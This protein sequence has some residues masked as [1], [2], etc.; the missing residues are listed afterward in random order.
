MRN[1]TLLLSLLLG[2]ISHYTVGQN[3]PL[4]PRFEESY[5]LGPRV[6]AKA[7]IHYEEYSKAYFAFD[8]ESGFLPSKVT[9]RGIE[10]NHISTQNVEGTEILI[11]GLPF[12]ER[13]L[14]T[15]WD[16][17]GNEI[18][19]QTLSS[20]PED[21]HTSG[22]EVSPRM[23]ETLVDWREVEEP[24][25]LI[26]Y[27]QEV[28]DI[29]P[30]EKIAFIQQHYLKGELISIDRGP[31]FPVFTTTDNCECSTV[32]STSIAEPSNTVNNTINASHE[33]SVNSS[34]GH[35]IS[36]GLNSSYWWY[37]NNKGPAKWHYLWGEG[38]KARSHT[39]SHEENTVNNQNMG[40]QRAQLAY[41][42]V[43]TGRERVPGDCKTCTKKLTLHYRYDSEVT[44][45]ARTLSGG[46]GDK[47]AEAIAQDQAVVTL[48]QGTNAPEVLAVQDIRSSSECSSSIN[49]DWF[50]S[51]VDLALPIAEFFLIG[52]NPTSLAGII[53]NSIEELI[54]EPIVER[55]DC[56]SAT[57]QGTLA[58]NSTVV[59]LEANEPLYLNIFSFS[60]QRIG[61]KRSWFSTSGIESDFYMMGILDS[62]YE[63]ETLSKLCCADKE[64][65]WLYASEDGPLSEPDLRSALSAEL[66]LTAPWGLPNDPSVI[67]GVLLPFQTGKHSHPGPC[68]AYEKPEERKAAN[69]ALSTENTSGE[70]TTLLKAT[71][72][73]DADV[74]LYDVQGRKL[75]ENRAQ[76]S[77]ANLYQLVIRSGLM[78]KGQ[79]YVVQ[80]VAGNRQEAY[81]LVL[82]N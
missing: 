14:A 9:I 46:T 21:I 73:I 35:K 53:S 15:T 13:F 51:L 22:I 17:C 18:E 81:K 57:N 52:S 72:M 1:L 4:D 31:A 12:G 2:F 32:N 30:Y 70:Q 19:L 43:C 45:D 28:N 71:E 33:E 59:Y 65:H 29:S 77:R 61:G 64:V 37:R 50:V 58:S 10:G 11:S 47:N 60:T 41:N 54:T 34:G 49:T 39:R 78:Q 8:S 67:G 23:F 26:D 75:W 36:M 20:N 7:M 40:P 42:L 79:L 25:A 5:C 74:I 44:A 82:K 66:G 76:V 56:G 68:M 63:I 24:I 16:A 38:F 69:P 6:I 48:R 27:L 80:V 3:A 55:G 62:G